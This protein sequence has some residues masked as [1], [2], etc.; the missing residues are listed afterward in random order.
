MARIRR[1]WT[2]SSSP[3]KKGWLRSPNNIKSLRHRPFV[4]VNP[5]FSF[6]S[7]SPS[8]MKKKWRNFSAGN[9]ASSVINGIEHAHSHTHVHTLTHSHTHACIHTCTH[10]LTHTYTHSHIPRTHSHTHLHTL[11]LSHSHT[12]GTHTYTHKFNLY[13]KIGHFF[14]I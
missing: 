4:V 14:L 7:H 5:F 1:F 11:T 10:T 8:R 13:E 3:N 9:I 12:P 6:L 2:T